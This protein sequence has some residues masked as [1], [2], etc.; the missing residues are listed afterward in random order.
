MI[1]DDATGSEGRRLSRRG[2]LAGVTAT[3]ATVAAGA[4]TFGTASAATTTTLPKS[5]ADQGLARLMAGNVRYRTG[6]SVNQGRDSVRRVATADKQNPFAVILSCADSR[7]APEVVFDEGVGDLFVVRV[8]GNTAETAIVQGSLEYGIATFDSVV[9]MVLGHQNCGAVKAALEQTKAPTTVLPGQIGAFVSPILPAAQSVQSL[10]AASQLDAAIAQN[11][12]NQVTAL[13]A[14]NP[15]IKPA[16]DAG[17]V[18]LVGAEYIL[19]TG[20]VQL[21]NS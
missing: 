6:H 19:S 8:A 18:K 11:V 10:P 13:G 20:R 9:L 2:L 5:T 7:V 12:E 3:A 21:F 4:A 15:I 16:V 1:D 14:L 17:K